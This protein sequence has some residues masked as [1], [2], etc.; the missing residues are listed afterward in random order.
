VKLYETIIQCFFFVFPNNLY[1]GKRLRR[2]KYWKKYVINTRGIIIANGGTHTVQTQYFV[3]E[4]PNPNYKRVIV[5][6]MSSIEIIV[7][8]SPNKYVYENVLKPIFLRDHNSV[9]DYRIS[10]GMPEKPFTYI[11]VYRP[12][13]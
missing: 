6:T 3:I 8:N 5:V 9:C 2:R 13:T 7:H 11:N 1:F 4:I 12:I 10:D